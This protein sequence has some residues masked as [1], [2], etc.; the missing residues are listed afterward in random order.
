M[1][2]RMRKSFK[3]VPGVRMTVSKSGVGVSAGVRGARITRSPSGRVT[4]TVSLSGTGLSHTKTVGGQSPRGSAA[5]GTRTATAP[6]SPIK[7]GLLA[8]KWEK[9]LYKAVLAGRYEDL[10]QIAKDNPDLAP[11][12]AALDGFKALLDADYARATDVLGWVWSTGSSIENH[13]FMSKYLTTSSITL[14]IADGVRA[15]LPLSRDAV[16]F[17]LVELHQEGGRLAEAIDIAEG[18]DP[19]SVAAVSLAELYLLESRYSDVIELTNG[20]ANGD[21]P[22]ALLATFR[23]IALR[24]EGHHTAAREAFKEALRSKARPSAIRHR[25]L[26]E[27]A[28]TN[29]LDGK[30]AM[31]RKDLERVLAED[32]TYAGIREAI[33]A[34]E[35]EVR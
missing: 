8:P 5:V 33:E 9:D 35:A 19:S 34:L 23:G 30:K 29:R 27:R 18:L 28:E 17:A 6:P 13:P 15:E 2:F 3:V 20:I 1:G 25:A 7:P 14:G 31:A 32:S 4:R 12:A 24:E 16:G 22:T 21:D 10:P 26:V 11:V